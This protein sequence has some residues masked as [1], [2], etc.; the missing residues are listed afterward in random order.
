[1][2]FW[3]LALLPLLFAPQPN[4]PL[5]C[6]TSA[7]IIDPNPKG[8]AV[9]SGPSLQH[10]VIKQ[11]PR[12]TTPPMLAIRQGLG[13]WMRVSDIHSSNGHLLLGGQGWI[14]GPSLAISVHGQDEEPAPLYQHPDTRTRVTAITKAHDQ[15][16]ITACNGA[17]LKVKSPKGE[18]WLHPDDQCGNPIAPC[19]KRR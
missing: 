6:D 15:L 1:M 9:R 14:Y 4:F 5:P 2:S 11:L 8:V 18:G 17:W 19:R 10:S 3:S 7:F 13:N 12:Q 16:R